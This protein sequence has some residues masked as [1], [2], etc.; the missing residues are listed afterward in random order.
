MTALSRILSLLVN[1][2]CFRSVFLIRNTTGTDFL[3]ELHT[4]GEEYGVFLT[5]DL[6]I[7]EL[8]VVTYIK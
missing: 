3:L 6:K 8:S 1:T 4:L 7:L 2:V 5:N